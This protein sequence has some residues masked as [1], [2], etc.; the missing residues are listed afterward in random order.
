MS[1]LKFRVSGTSGQSRDFGRWRALVF[2]CF[3][4]AA[5][6]LSVLHLLKA[7]RFRGSLQMVYLV[8]LLRDV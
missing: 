2:K 8:T 3:M 6:S 1:S 5:A 7:L 4:F